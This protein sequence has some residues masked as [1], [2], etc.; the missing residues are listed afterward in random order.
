[1]TTEVEWITLIIFIMAPV[2]EWDIQYYAAS[3][4]FVLKVDVL[5]QG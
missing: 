1:M 5:E 4:H 2:S 3:E